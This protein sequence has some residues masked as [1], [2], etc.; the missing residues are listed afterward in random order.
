MN[1][2]VGPILLSVNPY[3]EVGNALTLTSTRAAVQSPHLLRVVHEAVRQQS[4]TGYPQAIILSVDP[5]KS[6]L[7]KPDIG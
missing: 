6:D 5:P 7:N 1:T 2:N 4:E 3:H